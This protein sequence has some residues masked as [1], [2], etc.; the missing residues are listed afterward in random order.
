MLGLAANNDYAWSSLA[1][2]YV[3]CFVMLFPFF[4]FDYDQGCD[5]LASI[6]SCCHRSRRSEQVY[7]GIAITFAVA[8]PMAWC[9]WLDDTPVPI[10]GNFTNPIPT[11]TLATCSL[12]SPS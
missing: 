5:W 4:L 7:V 11:N 2:G 1:I 8:G 9:W 12:L 3:V 6:W 10:V